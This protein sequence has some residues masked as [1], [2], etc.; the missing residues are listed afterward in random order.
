[1]KVKTV[2]NR[3]LVQGLR[4]RVWVVVYAIGHGF[5]SGIRVG[6]SA[7]WALEFAG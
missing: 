2:P 6:A 3:C 1:M 5:D 4:F 7:L